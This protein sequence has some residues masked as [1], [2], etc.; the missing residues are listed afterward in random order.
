MSVGFC[1]GIK[2]STSDICLPQNFFA[3]NDAERRK[4]KKTRVVREE[5]GLAL[6]LQPNFAFENSDRMKQIAG[7]AQP[8]GS[9]TSKDNFN[10][11]MK[12]V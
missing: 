3:D 9:Y 2:T 11:D 1:N 4:K 12:E 5:A 7:I 8:D 6:G 10:N